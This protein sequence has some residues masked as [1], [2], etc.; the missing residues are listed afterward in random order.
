MSFSFAAIYHD[1]REGLLE[2]AGDLSE[3]EWETMAPAT[4]EWAVKDLY[5]HLA[6][7]AAD[8]L[9]G[10]VMF[11]GTDEWTAR[12]VGDRAPL[13]AGEICDEWR[14][15]GQQLDTLIGEVGPAL[16]AAVID[17]WHHEQDA[18][19]AIG[20]Q[21]NR[22]G[23]GLRLALRSGNAIGPKI[24]AAGLPTLAVTTDGYERLFGVGEPA[25][26]VAGP[27]YELARAFM[28]RRSLEQ[29]RG[30]DWS[31]DPEPYLPHFSV[32]APRATPLVE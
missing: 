23:E 22:S 5:A 19:N 28:G 7:V 1:I 3:G 16:S 14:A 32:F 26:S 25:V 17:V 9:A 27:P 11:P 29:I 18:R 15:S 13:T 2:L 10:N 31:G 21:A 24:G 12:Q 6:G 30:F 8:I 4:P 20:R